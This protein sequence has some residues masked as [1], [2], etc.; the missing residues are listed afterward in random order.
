MITEDVKIGEGT[1]I[2]HSELSNLYG[3]TIGKN[4]KIGV[5]VEIQRGVIIGDN[6]KV[7]SGVFIPTGVIIEDN[8]FLGPKVCFT[9]D[10]HPRATNKDGSLLTA[11]QWTITPTLVKKGAAIGAN[12]TIVCGVT[13]GEWALIG[14]GS[15]VTKD[16]PAGVTVYGNPARQKSVNKGT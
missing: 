4:C 8:V 12:S 9:N 15:V 11:D 13:I 16:V 2:Y 3:C 6:V 7:E 14:S 10:K 5:H 1:V